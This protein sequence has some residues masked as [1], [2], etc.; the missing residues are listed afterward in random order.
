MKENHKAIIEEKQKLIGK[1]FANKRIGGRYR[2]VN[3]Y[4]ETDKDDFIYEF[5]P[6]DQNKNNVMVDSATFILNW[7]ELSSH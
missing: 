5:Y 7:R 2:L 1:R 4:Y 6:V 3:V